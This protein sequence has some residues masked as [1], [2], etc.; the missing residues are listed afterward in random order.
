MQETF[1][2]LPFRQHNFFC[3]DRIFPSQ[4]KGSGSIMLTTMEHYLRWTERSLRLALQNT[5]LRQGLRVLMYGG[6]GF[7]LSA[8]ALAGSPQPL[9][10]GLVCA[11]TGWRALVSALGAALGY[12]LFW[13]AA[14][15]MGMVWAAAAC[16]LALVLGKTAWA[17]ERPLLIPCCAAAAVGITGLTFLFFRQGAAFSVFLTQMLLAPLTAWFAAR[18]RLHR[19][20]ITQWIWMGIGTLALARVVPVP[21]FSLGCVAAGAVSLWAS[22]PASAIAALG[23]DLAGIT[24]MPMAVMVCAAWFCRML[25][26]QH[27]WMRLAV[28]PSAWLAVGILSGVWDGVVLPGFALGGAVGYLLPPHRDSIHR[29][30][31]TGLAQVRLEMT[32][33][34]LSATQQLLLEVS[35][36]CPDREALLRRAE[37]AG[38]GSCGVRDSCQERRC[39]TVRHLENPEE[40]TCRRHQQMRQ[41][42]EHSR[43]LLRQMKADLQRRREYR[44]A[45]VQQYQFLSAYLR[46]LS[47]SLPRGGQKIRGYYR[48]EVSARSRGKEYANGDR[49]LAFAGTGCRY[50]VLLCD[51]MGTGLGAAQEGQSAAELL[52]QML[53]A[54]F[55]PE[56][57]LRSVN[58]I[59][60]LMGRSGAV[61]VDLAE[62]RLDSGRA[63][64]YKWGAAPSWV[65]GKDGV[66][67]LGTAGPP[68]GL[69]VTEARESVVRLSLCRG[70]T[71]ILVSDGVEAGECLGRKEMMPDLLPGELAKRLVEGCGAG[72]EDD[73]T[74]AVMRLHR[75]QPST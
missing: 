51:G 48:L 25:P 3:R 31:E 40:F 53:C 69:W 7:F 21:G 22:F 23:L 26:F 39:L 28:P 19:G 75:R 46:N 13:G 16:V 61:T 37:E 50:Y 1:T 68:P 35:D 72:A 42:L 60:A 57:A 62:I 9:A 58:S 24:P 30:G 10:M 6:S 49:C 52:K 38:C 18:S 66:K 32:A 29:R 54:G 59:L 67:K 64:V 71:L 20:S 15:N 34:V 11:M 14:G 27:R 12:R 44:S 74:A 5:P 70:E 73:A 17:E 47:D 56:H 63:A 4:R 43:Q 36:L 33:A 45:L 41:E 55:P 8:A 2:P 65:L